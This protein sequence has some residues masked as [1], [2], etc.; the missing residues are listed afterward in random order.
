MNIRELIERRSKASFLCIAIILLSLFIPSQIMTALPSRPQ[1]S[2]KMKN[3]F[4]TPD[5]AFP[6]TVAE[7]AEP[8]FRK[9]IQSGNGPEALRAAIQLSISESMIKSETIETSVARFDSIALKFKGPWKNLSQLIEAQLYASYYQSHQWQ[10]NKRTLPPDTS[11]DRSPAE[12]SRQ[13]FADRV[14]GLVDDAMKDADQFASMP[15]EKIGE[16]L[17]NL[18][19]TNKSLTVADF[20]AIQAVETLGIFRD[21]NLTIPFGSK[22]ACKVSCSERA[23]QIL[24][25][26]IER[27]RKSANFYAEAL[28]LDKKLGLLTDAERDEYAAQLVDRFYDTPFCAP[29]LVSWFSTL[30]SDTLSSKFSIDK[31]A[32]AKLK[33][34]RDKYPDA[35]GIGDV[36]RLIY[37]LESKNV[38]FIV[39][40]EILP[41]RNFDIAVSTNNVSD[42]YLMIFSVPEIYQFK[43]ISANDLKKQGRLQQKI[44]IS[45]A[46]EIPFAL[47]DTLHINPLS[48]GI[49]SL[50]Y[51]PDGSID[52]LLP[53]ER[54]SSMPSF[55]VTDIT[56]FT[57]KDNKNGKRY[58][59]VQ[60]ATDGS[61]VAEAKIEHIFT[62]GGLKP[63]PQILIADKE[64]KIE[65][66][67]AIDGQLLVNAHGA[68]T[69]L[70]LYRPYYHNYNTKESV[71]GSVMTDL[72]LYR[73]G[74]PMRFSAVVWAIDNHTAHS[75]NNHE[76]IATLLDA[77]YQEIDSLKLTTDKFGRVNGEFKLPESGLLGRWSINIKSKTDH[78]ADRS[79][80]VA[81]YKTPRFY[82]E[83]KLKDGSFTPGSELTIT[84]EAKTYTG[85]PVAAGK[86]SYTIIYSPF[87]FWWRSGGVS[88]ASYTGETL[89][90]EDGNFKIELSTERLKGTIFE[91]GAYAIAVEVTDAAGETREAPRVNF[92]LG[93]VYS[94]DA[95]LP[96]RIQADD[97]DFTFKASI[98]DGLGNPTDK[99][100]Y[101]RIIRNGTI[102]AQS[103]AAN[104]EITLTLAD[105]PSGRYEFEFAADDT[106]KASE[107]CEVVKESTIIWRESDTVPPVE[108]ILWIDKS[109]ITVPEDSKSVRIRVGSSYEGSYVFVTVGDTKEITKTEWIKIDK[110]FAEVQLPAP[111]A[112]DRIFVNISAIRDFKT[113]Q[114]SV[115]LIPRQQTLELVPEIITFRDNIT[116]GAQESWKIRF[117]YD[118]KDAG[119]IPVM[120]VMTNKALNAIVPFSWSFDPYSA[121]SWYSNYDVSQVKVYDKSLN[122][123]LSKPNR[124]SDK[125]LFVY[126]EW[127]TYGYGLFGYRTMSHTRMYAKTRNHQFNAML[128]STPSAENG[129]EEGG[130]EIIVEE[131]SMA[132][133]AMADDKVES[134]ENPEDQGAAPQVEDMRESECPIAFFMPSLTTDRAG[135][136]TIEFEAPQF[137]GTWQLQVLGY[138]EEMKG[139]VLTLDAISSKP[140]MVQLNAPRFARTGDKL[141]ISATVF[142]NSE[143]TQ[144]VIDFIELIDPVTG[145]SLQGVTHEAEILD[146]GKSAVITIEFEV[147]DGIEALQIKASAAIPG[148]RDGEQTI[149]PVL[150]SSAPVIDSTPF[151]IKAGAENFEIR[152][153]ELKNDANIILTY[154]NNPIWECVTA[155]PDIMTPKSSNILSQTYALFGNC[156]A[157]GL[158]RK[159][160]ALVDA[161]KT[162]AMDSTLY[163]PLEKNTELK[164][165]LLNN[166]PWV[167]NAQAET[168]RMQNLVKYDNPE[169]A[170]RAIEDIMLTLATRVNSDGGWGWC[171]GMQSSSFI[172]ERVFHVFGWLQNLGYLPTGAY[173][174]AAD[175][176]R[177]IESEFLKQWKR[178]DYKYYSLSGMT[179]Y[180]Y[181]KTAFDHFAYVP[182]FERLANRAIADI[183]KDWRNF[184]I[185]DKATAA[186]L[187]SRKGYRQEALTIIES[188]LQF[189][190]E[191]DAKGMWFDT[192]GGGY[193]GMKRIY[194]TTRVLE[195]L[196]A[197][198]PENAAIDKLRQWL[199]VSKQ[200]MNWGEDRFTADAINA[201]LTCG[202]DWTVSAAQPVILLSGVELELPKTEALTGALKINLNPGTASKALLTIYRSGD[203]PAW[204]GVIAQYISPIEDVKAHSIDELSIKKEIV[205]LNAENGAITAT[206][207]N[208][209][210]GDKVR[211]TLTITCDRDIEYVAI[212]DPRPACLEPANQISS[213]TSSDGLWYY[214][215]VRTSDTNLFISFLPKGAHV[216]NYECFVD[217]E[218]E[219]ALGPV[220]AQ[221]Q[222]APTI[223]AHSAGASCIVGK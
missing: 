155:L 191:T 69:S 17:D 56:C 79:F 92:V 72:A 47:N 188:I 202:S 32:Y 6:Q 64:G 169:E 23:M 177:Y 192:M 145:R 178:S 141:F 77:N 173:S 198:D 19:L 43:A 135:I 34:Y 20:L 140:V 209:K 213:F 109:R 196:A 174:L 194:D 13:M 101:Y 42:G 68:Q 181:A 167:N 70:Y 81:E 127:L 147:P 165:V 10:I 88:D 104:G 215:E 99:P 123:A 95:K 158:M 128:T 186:M 184:D 39:K 199:I 55:R 201:L 1:P 71:E 75:L 115:T 183:R 133:G 166:T 8:R 154:C 80:Q 143:E 106:F 112:N 193:S 67:D 156:I 16:I 139:A 113:E 185:K 60:S 94:I 49:Y 9:A 78:I 190:S 29:F 200:T 118:E 163:S 76:L 134:I 220:S 48:S 61:P 124:V 157:D 114:S 148:H 138:N 164:S 62:S 90:D 132:M 161:V 142:N 96:A 144:S 180:L 176:S 36:E 211:V 171:P 54:Y 84:G 4:E 205:A 197:I 122:V 44:K 37:L 136:A 18:K 129:V 216:I 82:V 53:N 105:M 222:Y 31:E 41:G 119:T 206:S 189:A 208:L 63:L 187:L 149:I 117:N 5:F 179:E 162:M 170:R 15:I 223:S 83:T 87:R 65:V 26:A 153:P 2:K 221:S 40:D 74:D 146:A 214:R 30:N 107:D 21:N 182:G 175:A 204:G 219:Y 207:G 130:G 121:I 100:V 152:L 45:G 38:D 3:T 33:A 59:I 98:N 103:H 66:P 22:S 125:V 12:W 108:S 14:I 172:T 93:N 168:L 91:H 160:P 131:K 85:M 212:T 102:V 159:Y 35:G 7:N 58:L 28:F 89:T 137:T 151:Y 52:N 217:R 116:P 50:A 120:A 150:P 25:D 203:G 46:G 110:G 195:A 126:P 111:A 57:V 11:E 97:S 27:S 73:P 24:N 51:S 210:V 218:G 86:V